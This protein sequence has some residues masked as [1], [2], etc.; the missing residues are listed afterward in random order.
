[1]CVLMVVTF[2]V[3][4]LN[5]AIVKYVVLFALSHVTLYIDD[6]YFCSIH[7]SK[8]MLYCTRIPL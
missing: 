6:K 4:S 1:M 7:G 8:D 5:V 2:K 3:S